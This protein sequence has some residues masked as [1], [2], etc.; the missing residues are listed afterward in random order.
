M[1]GLL[2]ELQQRTPQ[3]LEHLEA[4][5]AVESPSADLTATAKAADAADAL[6]GSLLG[7]PCERIEDAGR[8]HLRWSG[9]GPAS[10]VLVMHVDTVWPMGTLGRWPFAVSGDRATGPGAFDMK[11][12]V[13]QGLHALSLLPDLTGVRVVI[14][15]DEEIGSPTSRGLIEETAAGAAAALVL[16]P[17]AAGALKS[18]RKGVSLYELEVTGRA[19]HAG[20]EP[21]RGVNAAIELAHQ[22]LALETVADAAAGTT[23]TPTL[24]SGGTTTNTVPATARVAVDVRAAVA[25]EQ[26]RVDDVLR[27]LRPELP[28]ARLT[29]HGGPNRPPLQA[30]TSR[31]LVLRAQQLAQELGLPPLLDTAVGGGS[32]G[33]F[34]AGIGVPTLDGLGA[35]GDGAHA[36]GEYVVVSAMPER[37]A[38]VAALVTDLLRGPVS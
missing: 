10:V 4:L 3:L 31:E 8:V 18:A 26:D 24:L 12:G 5:V 38:L 35:V 30:S 36:E 23:V 9:G 37:A 1:T 16:E 14:T 27:G 21:E 28:G 34:T 32:D 29:L 25:A 20:L 17:S 6:V 22:L 13:V 2:R 19:A 33:N 11:A 15:T 7:S